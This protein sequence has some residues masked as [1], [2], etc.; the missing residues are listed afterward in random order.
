M[1]TRQALSVAS[2]PCGHLHGAPL[3]LVTLQNET[4]S[5]HITN[6]G[7]AVMAIYTPDRHGRVK[8]IVA[9][10]ARPLDYAH[11]PWYLGS[12]V[13]RY[14]NRIAAGRF[15]LDGQA[16]QLTVNNDH[17]HLHGGF[18]GFHTKV[19]TLVSLVRE[20]AHTGVE[21]TCFS[22][23]GEEGYPGNLEVK[24]R[25]LLNHRHQLVMEYRAVTD[26]RTPVSITNHS[27]FNLSGFEQAVVQDHLLH[28][29]AQHYTEKNER[30]LPTG[31]ILPLKGTP[32]DFTV[33]ARLGDRLHLFPQD[34]GLDHN[35]VLRR[36]QP[37]AMV[38]AATLTDMDTGRRLRVFTDQHGM[39]VYTAN[40]W[41]GS[42]T[43]QQGR[44]YVQHG[45]IALETQA[46]P[47]SPNHAHFPGAI[48]EPGE[49]YRTITVYEFG[50]NV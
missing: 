31:R 11:N 23:D 7:C 29:N 2:R 33:P 42:I 6:L 32:A 22:E 46:F 10:L 13:G 49:E 16:V 4:I 48:L 20:E 9:G 14:A 12:V 50:L 1:N 47:D 39:Q 18:A 15:M 35:Y 34:C 8:N 21:F 41:D 30:N 36:H 44:P 19:W 5:V 38:P 25:Y 3:H 17:N 27:Y 43:G 45:A 24:V 37:G 26:K 28:I 40:F